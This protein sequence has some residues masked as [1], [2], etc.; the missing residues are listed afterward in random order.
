MM[1]KYRTNTPT[2]IKCF[3]SMPSTLLLFPL[4]LRKYHVPNGIKLKNL[5]RGLI[6]SLAEQVKT[7][8]CGTLF[9]VTYRHNNVSKQ[10]IMEVIS[11]SISKDQILTRHMG[12]VP[13]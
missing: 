12:A 6:N 8:H 1:P 9:S 11:G 13:S 10:L 3:M 5:D 2:S 4:T 7:F